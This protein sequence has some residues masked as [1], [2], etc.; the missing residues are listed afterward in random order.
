YSNSVVS[1]EARAM[2]SLG[3]KFNEYLSGSVD[4]AYYGVH[5]NK[6]FKQNRKMIPK[7]H[8]AWIP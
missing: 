8:H 2:I 4:L 5:T 6:G 3:Y 7:R 1:W